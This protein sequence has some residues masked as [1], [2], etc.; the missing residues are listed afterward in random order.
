MRGRF[1]A[2]LLA[3]LCLW[4]V[5]CCSP[6]RAPAQADPLTA[7]SIR[8]V[9]VH[10]FDF[11]S[12]PPD[13]PTLT[14]EELSGIA[15]IGDDRYLAVGD[16]HAAL[17]RLTIRV[18]PRTG[19]VLS[20][21]I[22]GAIPL[23]DESG[24]RV[25]EPAMAEDREALAYDPAREEVWVANEHT[26][27][28]KRRPSIAR[29]RVS[30][31]RA[32][33]LLRMNADSVLSV[34]D[35]ARS[36]RGFESLARASDGTVWTA[37]EDAL[38]IDGPIGGRTEGGVVRLQRLDAEMIPGAQHAYRVDPWS[39]RIRSPGLLSG[40]EI[41]GLSELVALPGGRLLA[42]ER[43]LCGDRG[44]VATLR[45]RLY[46]VDV[47]GATDVS[48]REFRS[49]LAGKSYVAARKVLLW[50]ETWGLT[51]SNFEAMTLG[52][53]LEDGS[54][55]LILLADNNAGTSQALFTM[56]MSGR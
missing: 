32:T 31:G 26:G 25:P 40:R 50:Q 38:R 10:R 54:R 2:P 11:E 49:G 19:R 5:A 56:R 4:A 27:T 44:G 17:H 8:A 46:L 39:M 13:D 35:R 34:F 51:N 42:L 20:A 16:A 21:E 18:D 9:P 23:R 14:P 1:F 29:H 41:S 24:A 37:N 3:L 6:R 12:D 53:T 43:A 36:N 28:D 48:A 55:L 7:D 15:W 47:S 33:A 22:A 30:D 45:S 52:P